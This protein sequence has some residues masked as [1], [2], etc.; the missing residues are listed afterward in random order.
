[1]KP[2]LRRALRWQGIW[3]IVFVLACIVGLV[4]WL[5]GR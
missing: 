4:Q 2:E 5:R 3:F 1:V